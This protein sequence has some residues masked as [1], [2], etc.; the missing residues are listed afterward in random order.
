MPRETWNEAISLVNKAIARDPKFTLAYCLLNEI[1]VLLYR[2][3]DDHSPQHLAAAKNAAETALRLEPKSEEAHLALARYYY[4]GLSDYRQTQ[5]ELSSLP[6]SAAHEVEFF[7]LASLVERRLGQFEASIRNGEKAVELDPQNAALAVSLAQTYSGLRRFGDSERVVNAAIAR[8]HGPKPARLFVAKNEAALGTGNMKAARVALDSTPD[9]N[10]M[11]YQAARLWLCFI[12]R[13]YSAAKP[14][15]ANAADEAK[16]IPDFWLAFAAIAHMAGKA[17]DERQANEKARRLAMVAL[18]PRPNDPNILGQLAIAEAGLGQ[19]EEA[20]RHARQ[21]AGILPPSVDAVLGP[22][23]EMRLAEVLVMTGDRDGAFDS[24]GKLA[25][26]PFGAN[27]G[28]LKLNPMW[29]DLRNDA[30]FDRLLAESGLPL[31]TKPAISST[32]Q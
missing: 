27:Q 24:L 20:V 10:D 13:D 28:D 2:F 16:K 23:C 5:R 6:S 4:H 19:N 18:G 9:K 11:D 1:Y 3:G 7:T 22:S 21:A 31:A 32:R 12:E 30:R 29:D 15:V 14:F 17:D 25:K 8:L 26:L